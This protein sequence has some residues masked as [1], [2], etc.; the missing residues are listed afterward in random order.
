MRQQA[1][2]D[3]VKKKRGLYAAEGGEVPDDDEEAPG[4][5]DWSAPAA[6][7]PDPEEEL[8]DDSEPNEETPTP[9]ES[10]PAP[11][12]DD[13]SDDESAPEAP[14]SA[15]LDRDAAI[16]D[17]VS[18]QYAKVA[19]D[20]GIKKARDDA[21][22]KNMLAGIFSGLQQIV[23]ARGVANGMKPD[24]GKTWQALRDQGQQGIAQAQNERNNAINGFLRQN[25]LNHQLTQDMLTRGSIEQKQQAAKREA[26]RQDPGSTTSKA[27]QGQ[28]KGLWGDQLGDI[29]VSGMSAAQ[30]EKLSG[31]LDAKD[32]IQERGREADARIDASKAARDEA[33]SRRGAIEEDRA[34]KK[35]T[36]AKTK[37]DE[38]KGTNFKNM[39]GEML[40]QGRAPPDFKQALKDQ[41]SIDKANELFDS[42]KDLN[43]MTKSEAALAAGELEKIATGGAGTEAGRQGLDPHSFQE[44]WADFKNKF[45]GPDGSVDPANIGPFL[46]KQK[47]YLQG[48]G[49]VTQTRINKYRRDVYDGYD[50]GDLIADKHR[51]LTKKKHP[52]LFPEEQENAKAPA[53]AAPTAKEPAPSAYP[54][55]VSNGTHQATV[56]NADEEKQAAAKGFK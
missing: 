40:G 23:T 36:A 26:D 50:G 32:K 41:Q 27:M 12:P 47:D 29:D 17:F 48:L 33:N 52:E 34:T 51:E 5:N 22:R 25:A 8:P 21:G 7:E 11:E 6:S 53:E 31:H 20:S 24:D 19:D 44:S 54:K 16:R 38:K 1:V 45:V 13:G 39:N 56:A 28:V 46:Q 2:H 37:A 4:S 49:K 9:E 55:T 14:K 35:E 10:A 3:Y 15:P 42:H 30:L 18:K 43:T